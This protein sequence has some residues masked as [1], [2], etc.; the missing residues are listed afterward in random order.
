MKTLRFAF[1]DVDDTLIAIKSM[2][3]FI[4][5]WCAQMSTPREAT[6]FMAAFSQAIALGEAREMLNRRYYR[7]FRGVAL[8]ELN[9]TG[10]KWFMHRFQGSSAPYNASIVA[11][12]K[13]HRSNG[14]YPVLVSGSMPP[15]LKPIA[16]DLGIEHCLCTRLLV[17]SQGRLTGEIGTPQTIG[18]G[19]ADALAAFLQAHSAAANECFA[20]GDDRSDVPMLEAVGTPV[21]VGADV[22]LITI[23][24][25]RHWDL[26]P[27]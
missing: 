20:Y 8:G 24:K 1:F 15:L 5:F 23:A 25:Q 3:D 26:L 12:L 16:D 4:P 11:R 18:A 27:V 2:I 17:D 10:S 13:E 14:V 21:A 7:L 19:K 6:Q 22:D 9:A